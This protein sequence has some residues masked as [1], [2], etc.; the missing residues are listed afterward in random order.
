MKVK[1]TPYLK[2]F[3]VSLLQLRYYNKIVV[4]KYI[5]EQ[6]NDKK[7][8]KLIK[9]IINCYRYPHIGNNMAVNANYCK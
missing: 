7:H 8:F 2:R 6:F 1:K 5:G 9:L 3:N 4:I